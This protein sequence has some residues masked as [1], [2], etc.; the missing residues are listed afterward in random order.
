M[1][2]Q[3]AEPRLG[4]VEQVILDELTQRSVVTPREVLVR[5]AFPALGPSDQARRNSA[6]AAVSRAIRSLERKGLVVRER[7]GRTGRTSV[8]SPQRGA[9]PRW[10]Q[11]A[12]AEEDLAAH[13][14]MR[15]AEWQQLASRARTRAHRIRMEQS[16]GLTDEGRRHDLARIAHLDP[17]GA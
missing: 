7:D 16:S 14:R 17:P 2:E 5:T 15:A 4:W 10:E 12:R 13:C 6:E 9:L 8:R 3:G 11:L 1:P